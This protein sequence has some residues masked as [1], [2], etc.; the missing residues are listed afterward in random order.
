MEA[1]AV[2]KRLTHVVV[3]LQSLK[4]EK[5]FSYRWL[6]TPPFPLQSFHDVVYE[7][8][9]TRLLPPLLNSECD[10]L[11]LSRIFFSLC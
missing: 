7:Q 10:A 11:L 2:I 8:F 3:H 1:K 9:P 6:P 5:H 4:I